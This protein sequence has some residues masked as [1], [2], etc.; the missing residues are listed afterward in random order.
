MPRDGRV[1]CFLCGWGWFP[2]IPCLTASSVL[3][4]PQVVTEC[5]VRSGIR[6][7]LFEF[8]I[9]WVGGTGPVPF[10]GLVLSGTWACLVAGF[11]VGGVLG[12]WVSGSGEWVGVGVQFFW[13]ER[14]GGVAEVVRDGQCPVESGD[15]A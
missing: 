7:Q 4:R 5:H 11:G 1:L 9:S 2:V 6:S 10:D 12:F 8:R 13:A 3:L 14:S 15:A